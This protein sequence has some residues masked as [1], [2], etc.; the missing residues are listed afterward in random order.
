MAYLLGTRRGLD[1]CTRRA[2]RSPCSPST[3]ARTCA[4]SCA[5]RTRRPSRR[6]DGRVQ[7]GGRPGA[8]DDG[9]GHPAR[10]GDRGRPAIA[11][12]SLPGRAGL[13]VAVEATGYEGPASARVS[14]VLPGWGVDAGQAA[15]R[16]GGQAARLLPPGR[17]ERGGPGAPRR[18]RRRGVPRGGPRAVPRAAVVRPRRAAGSPARHAGRRGRD[19]AAADRPRR[20]RPQGG[21]PLRR[22]RDRRGRWREACDEL[23]AATPLPWVLLSG[24]RRRRHV[25]APGRASRAGRAPAACSS[26][27]PCGRGRDDDAGGSRRVPRDDRSRSASRDSSRSSTTARSPVAAALDGGPAAGRAR[28]LVRSGTD[29]DGRTPAAPSATS[30][31]SSPARSTRTSS[32]RTRTRARC[33]ARPSASSTPSGWRS[34]ARPSITACGAARLGLRVA[35]VGVVGD[36]ELGR[37]MLEAMAERGLDIGACVPTGRPREPR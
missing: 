5:R 23:D 18:R 22:R 7:A 1:A 17:A 12:G 28:G 27:A 11:D 25:R 36:D 29:S 19:R 21:V 9:H 31:C 37:F 3:I 13:I 6:R 8:R 26:G 14:R 16:I 10:P 15:R 2:A 20:G 30:T 24:G 33:S 4:R 35:M 32:S 34:A